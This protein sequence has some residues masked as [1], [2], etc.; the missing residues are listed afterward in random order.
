MGAFFL[1]NIKTFF[2][3]FFFTSEA[4]SLGLESALY[5]KCDVIKLNIHCIIKFK[6]Y[7]RALKSQKSNRW[8][9]PRESDGFSF[10]NDDYNLIQEYNSKEEKSRWTFLKKRRSIVKI[11][12]RESYKKTNMLLFEW[13]K[14][15]NML[16]SKRKTWIHEGSL[17]STR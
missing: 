4:L 11:W 3:L 13:K 15:L 17:E 6:F 14:K 5:M 10:I 16:A 2:L 1:C 7:N 9:I 12:C 8:L